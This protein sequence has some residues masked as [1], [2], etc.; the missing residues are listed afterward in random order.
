MARKEDPRYLRTRQM[1][2]NSFIDLIELHQDYDKITVRDIV[3]HAGINRSTF[4]LHFKDKDDLFAEMKNEVILELSKSLYHP[5]Y[6]FDLALQEF[7]DHAKPIVTLVSLSHHVQRYA[8]FYSVMLGH[9]DF[10]KGVFDAIRTVLLKMSDS[11]LDADY[12]AG[13]ILGVISH[14]VRNGLKESADEMSLW[15]TRAVLIPVG[16]A[17]RGPEAPTA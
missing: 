17:F 10:L 3:K 4:Y 11:E 14:W 8:R 2:C 7:N 16:L 9:G 5:T 15:L 12:T 1:L 13:G 6:D